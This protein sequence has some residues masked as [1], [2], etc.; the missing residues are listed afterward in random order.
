MT[1]T[2]K[3]PGLSNHKMMYI[4]HEAPGIVALGAGTTYKV[5]V[6]KY[7]SIIVEPSVKTA[8]TNE[9]KNTGKCITKLIESENIK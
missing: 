6:V 7:I 8:L 5:V 3:T 1:V 2:S 9:Q 4:T